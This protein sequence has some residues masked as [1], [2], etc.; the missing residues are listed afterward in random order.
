MTLD[1]HIP[2]QGVKDFNGGVQGLSITFGR[3]NLMQPW[4]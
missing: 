2:V 1:I 3:R 4:V